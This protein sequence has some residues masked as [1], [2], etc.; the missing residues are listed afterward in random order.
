MKQSPVV[1]LLGARQVGKTT[2][3]RELLKASP[4]GAT[5]F[6]LED[7]RDL[8]Q[9]DEPMLALE[10][11]RGIVVLDE[12]QRRPELFPVLRVLADRPRTPARFLVL[13]SASPSLLRQSSESLAGRIAFHQLPGLDLEEV[14]I[15]NLERLWF[16]GGYPRGY[17][18]RSH[19][20]GQR[21]LRDFTMTFVERDMPNLGIGIPPRT[22]ERFW[23]MLAHYHGQ[24]WNASDFARSFGVSNT[25]VR[26]YLDVLASAFV[27]QVLRPWAENVGKRVVKSPKVF[28]ADSGVLHVLLGIETPHVL[29]RHPKLGAS[30]EGFILAQIV[31]ATRARPEESY[32][33]ATHA[34]AELDLLIASGQHRLAFEIKR[35]DAPKVTASMRAAMETLRLKQLNVIHAGSRTYP[36]APGIRAVSCQDITSQLK[37][38]RR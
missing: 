25:T 32:F 10:R 17:L 13:G 34:G 23:T 28:L 21:W 14:G 29:D 6:D 35:T 1:A 27:V 30:W 18:A 7:P 36:M 5:F 4:R 24:V 37:P 2:L 19:A 33:W 15:G 16:R 26:K 38:I 3:A 20:Q 12:I 9:L 11:L 8:A 22:L 31:R